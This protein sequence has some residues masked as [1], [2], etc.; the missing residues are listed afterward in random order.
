M[1]VDHSKLV[2]FSTQLIED[3]LRRSQYNSITIERHDYSRIKH[4]TNHLVAHIMHRNLGS[5]EWK[6]AELSQ[7]L[8]TE[9]D[10]EQIRTFIDRDLAQLQSKYMSSY[11]FTEPRRS[12]SAVD[13]LSSQDYST[14]YGSTVPSS[15]TSP[16]SPTVTD[17]SLT[18]EGAEVVYPVKKSKWKK[19]FHFFWGPVRPHS[20]RRHHSK[21]QLQ[22]A[23]SQE[24]LISTWAR[25]RRATYH[26]VRKYPDCAVCLE[27][28]ALGD[29]LLTL[30]CF[31]T[32]HKKCTDSW[33]ALHPDCPVC[34]VNVRKLS[35]G[36]ST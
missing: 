31:H 6:T 2:D 7:R 36:T 1:G 24:D 27:E 20:H 30:P 11:P 21:E 23:K 17:S 4:H 12:V 26:Q 28:F 35:N 32:F 3:R 10:L 13:P 25:V 19:K 14:I 5:S 15:P 29:V 16:S 34:R 9:N 33:L 18:L 8:F 22:R